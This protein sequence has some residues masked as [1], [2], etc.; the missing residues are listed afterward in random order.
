MS[1]RTTIG[2][3]AAGIAAAIRAGT[4]SA[5]AVCETA[6]ASAAAAPGIFWSLN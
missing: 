1:A 2:S 5:A 4:V 3:D 6:L